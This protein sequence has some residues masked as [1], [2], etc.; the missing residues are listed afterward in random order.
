MLFKECA[1]ATDPLW[2]RKLGAGIQVGLCQGLLRAAQATL[3]ARNGIL[4]TTYSALSVGS[5]KGAFSVFGKAVTIAEAQ[6]QDSVGVKTVSVFLP[7]SQLRL[8]HPSSGLKQHCS[9]C[10]P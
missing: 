9:G 1:L 4:N 2:V 6:I 8:P 10:W 3:G 7:Q 5:T